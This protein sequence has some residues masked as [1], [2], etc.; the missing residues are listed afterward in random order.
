MFTQTLGLN[1]NKCNGCSEHCILGAVP[2]KRKKEYFMPTIKEKP[3]GY[4]YDKNNIR[5]NLRPQPDKYKA[6]DTARLIS[7]L[8][9]KYDHHMLTISTAEP[10]RCEGCLF[11]CKLGSIKVNNG[12]LPKIDNDIIYT[13]INAYGASKTV[14]PHPQE[15]SA[16]ELAERIAKRCDFYKKHVK[17]VLFHPVRG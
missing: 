9:P 6:I 7:K 10:N 17:K 15:T 13:Y 12:F 5:H 4:Y 2:S 3:R 16:Q 11:R 8:C 14:I 1:T